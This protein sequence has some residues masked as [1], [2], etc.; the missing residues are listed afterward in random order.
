ML[1]EI[2]QCTQDGA[3]DGPGS[4]MV[5]PP[6]TPIMGHACFGWLG[7]EDARTDILLL[8][9]RSG[10]VAALPV[11][12]VEF[13]SYEPSVGI[14]LEVRGKQIRITGRNLNVPPQPLFEGIVT[15]RVPWIA[16]A[17]GNASMG[18]GDAAIVV[19]SITY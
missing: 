2:L 16:E 7:P 13:A 3:A 9:H 8:R 18:A 19:E 6:G 5:Q 12:W 4:A 14:T 17:M 11:A 15:R 10:V 1:S